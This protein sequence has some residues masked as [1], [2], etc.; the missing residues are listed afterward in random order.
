[1]KI[2]LFLEQ[3]ITQSKVKRGQIWGEVAL[4]LN[5]TSS[6]KFNDFKCSVRSRI[7]LL[8]TK[9]KEKTTKEDQGSGIECEDVTE[10]E[11]ALAEVTE[12]EQAADLDSY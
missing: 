6:P 9:Y 5:G 3:F 10:L 11:M 12:K 7:T 4:S 2:I 1:M 8:V